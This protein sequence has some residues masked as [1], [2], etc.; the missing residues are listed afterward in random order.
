MVDG[1]DVLVLQITGPQA[2]ATLF[3]QLLRS[4]AADRPTALPTP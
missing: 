3:R 1:A 4:A 2:N